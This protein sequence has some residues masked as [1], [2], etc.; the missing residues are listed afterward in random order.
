[1]RCKEGKDCPSKCKDNEIIYNLGDQA[2]NQCTDFELSSLVTEGRKRYK[3]DRDQWFCS[4]NHVVSGVGEGKQ[5]QPCPECKETFEARLNAYV[6]SRLA[7]LALD[8][9]NGV[10]RQYYKSGGVPK[11]ISF[12]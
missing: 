3:L 8:I 1:M 5:A 6:T 2:S 10:H 7:S 4:N 11:S 9:T 12:N